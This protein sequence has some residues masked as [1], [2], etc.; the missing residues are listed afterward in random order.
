MPDRNSPADP[1]RT[2]IGVDQ[3]HVVM[4]AGTVDPIPVAGLPAPA[5]VT[6][7]R[8]DHIAFGPDQSGPQQ[9]LDGAQR[10]ERDAD[11]TDDGPDH[12][13]CGAAGHA[14]NVRRTVRPYM[15]NDSSYCADDPPRFRLVRPIAA[16]NSVLLP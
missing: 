1:D 9:Q 8:L 14:R 5:G 2:C 4:M 15:G 7:G 12:H 6:A 10:P 3:Q 13:D 16:A 11:A